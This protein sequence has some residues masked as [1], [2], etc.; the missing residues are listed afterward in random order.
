[1]R[2]LVVTYQFVDGLKWSDGE[3]VSKDDYEL[4][5]H[6]MCDPAIRRRSFSRILS[7]SIPACDQIAGRNFN[8][9]TYRDVKP[10]SIGS[11]ASSLIT[12]LL[13]APAPQSN[14]LRW[15]HTG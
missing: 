10:G 15:A 12:C 6:A 2:Q 14:R 9:T 5:Y 7:R 11:P 13:Q 8:D 1:M 4:A 3:S